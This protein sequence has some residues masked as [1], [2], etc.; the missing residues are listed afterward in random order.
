[1]RHRPDC[2]GWME[3]V[4]RSDVPPRTPPCGEW[5]P[6]GSQFVRTADLTAVNYSCAIHLGDV[7]IEEEA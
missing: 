2:R 4:G 6:D 7:W 1:M 3:R 5:R